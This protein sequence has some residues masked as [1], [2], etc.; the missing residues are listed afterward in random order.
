MVSWDSASARF[1][2]LCEDDTDAE[3]LK[4]LIRRIAAA[5]GSKPG[6]LGVRHRSAEG[7]GHLRRKAA[8]WARELVDSGYDLIV[9]V[10]DLDRSRVRNTLNDEGVLR[11]DLEAIVMP[12]DASDTH[13][14]IPVEEFEAWFF[15]CPNVM[16]FVTG[17]DAQAHPT[18]HNIQMPKES[19]QRLS[20][21]GNRRP[22]ISTNANPKLAELL[23]LDAC[24]RVCPAFRDLREFV[25]RY[26]ASRRPE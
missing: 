10:H 1:G 20:R 25:C 18:P 2:L 11:R 21:A 4:V 15:A 19:L 12:K 17:K 3:A 6:A 26:T 22:R 8:V 9:L 16:R 23:D 7:C 5:A 14:C 13:L 24:A